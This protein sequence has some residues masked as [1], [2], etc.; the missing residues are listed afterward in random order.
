MSST[1][2]PHRGF[3]N[4]STRPR[5]LDAVGERHGAP[6][7]A[8]VPKSCRSIVTSPGV[9]RVIADRNCCWSKPPSITCTRTG[10]SPPPPCRGAPER[11]RRRESAHRFQGAAGRFAVPAASRPRPRRRRRP[12]GETEKAAALPTAARRITRHENSEPLR[13]SDGPVSTRKKRFLHIFPE[14]SRGRRATPAPL[15]P[16]RSRPSVRGPFA[17]LREVASP[18]WTCAL[19]GRGTTVYDRRRRRRRCPVRPW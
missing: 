16:G 18:V 13:Q 9:V 2:P 17:F 12:V 1:S 11:P 10:R 4:C 6:R 7:A 3:A 8:K 14:P 15:S 19:D 5:L